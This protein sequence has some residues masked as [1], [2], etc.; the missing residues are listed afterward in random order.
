M[1]VGEEPEKININQYRNFFWNDGC[2]GAS[3]VPVQARVFGSSGAGRVEAAQ[4]GNQ[5]IDFN[6]EDGLAPGLWAHEAASADTESPAVS[7]DFDLKCVPERQAAHS[8]IR[9]GAPRSSAIVSAG[10]V[11]FGASLAF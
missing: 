8:G 6:S 4:S 3:D 11:A 1:G 2:P 7:A 10:V 9:S 5:R